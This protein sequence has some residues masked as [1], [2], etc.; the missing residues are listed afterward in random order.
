LVASGADPAHGARGR[1]KARYRGRFAPTPSGPLHFGSV[2]AALGSYLEARIRDGEWHVR[3]DDLDPPRIVPGAADDIL[4]CLE[5]LGFEWD[6]PV[7]YQSRR[8]PAY[9]AAL[10]RLCVRGLVYPCACSRKEIAQHARIGIEGPIYPG[11]CRD[12]MPAGRAAR[13]L[14]LR[15]LGV[16]V[17]FDDGVLDAQSHDIEH[18][19]GDFT[20]YRA[21]GVFSFH[22]AS[23]VDDAELGMTDIVRGADLL[24]SSARQIHLMRLLGLPVPRYAHLPVVVNERGEKLSKQA[25]AAPIDPA[26]AGAV[27]Y[28]ALQ[29]LGQA[30]PA[31]LREAPAPDIWRWARGHWDLAR[32]RQREAG[33]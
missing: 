31:R 16:R 19:A 21:E 7:V 15:T 23:A 30:P 13:A 22:L 14:R 5:G 18:D 17:A 33:G 1:L 9:H 29:F 4:R 3:I 20:L 32:V 25:R 26:E 12:G 28:A 8:T 11:T 10:H 27:L 2:V 24:E 6:G